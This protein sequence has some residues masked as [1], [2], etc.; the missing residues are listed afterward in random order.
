MDTLFSLGACHT[1]DMWPR[2]DIYRNIPQTQIT[3]GF[4][5]EFEYLQRSTLPGAVTECLFNKLRFQ[6]NIFM[7]NINTH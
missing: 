1:C 5:P 7:T 3:Q 2:S 4:E 6:Y